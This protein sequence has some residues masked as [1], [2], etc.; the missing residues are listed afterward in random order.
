MAFCTHAQ[1][2][3]PLLL[4]VARRYDVTAFAQAA[5]A[6]YVDAPIANVGG[7]VAVAAAVV[8]AKATLV[9][10]A[11]FIHSTIWIAPKDAC[12]V[13]SLLNLPRP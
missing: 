12:E 3:T 13:A 9:H 10:A 8:S 7:D 2:A 5:V 4:W 6:K 1:R 11:L